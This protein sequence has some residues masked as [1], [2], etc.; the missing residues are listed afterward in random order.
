M[1]VL[2]EEDGINRGL[3][4]FEVLKNILEWSDV[5]FRKY[6]SNV[7]IQKERISAD[8]AEVVEVLCLQSTKYLPGEAK[9]KETISVI[10]LMLLNP[11]IE[12]LG[13]V[14]GKVIEAKKPGEAHFMVRKI[15]AIRALGMLETESAVNIL[16]A[17]SSYTHFYNDLE[18]F[19]LLFRAYID[20]MVSLALLHDRLFS[21][22]ISQFLRE[23]YSGLKKDEL[24]REVAA[25]LGRIYAGSNHPEAAKMLLQMLNEERKIIVKAELI[26]AL[27]KLSYSD[28]ALKIEVFRKVFSEMNFSVE[29]ALAGAIFMLRQEYRIDIAQRVILA[30][31]NNRSP[32]YPF[33]YLYRRPSEPSVT[34][35]LLE[36]Q[37]LSG[38][39]PRIFK[40][41]DL[42]QG[43]LE[44][45]SQTSEEVSDKIKIEVLMT[46]ARYGEW[47][48]VLSFP[49]EK[50]FPENKR[51]IIEVAFSSDNI[52]PSTFRKMIEKLFSLYDDDLQ[53]NVFELLRHNG[54]AVDQKLKILR[55]DLSETL[56][57]CGSLNDLNNRGYKNPFMKKALDE[58]LTAIQ[59]TE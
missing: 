38:L 55:G 23:M 12:S 59:E 5:A 24:R 32:R 9:F 39:Q 28:E 36:F 18:A 49:F 48:S 37:R 58:L 14:L 8:I 45:L 33:F 10:A 21:P 42:R 3:I 25:A 57:L 19:P 6:L 22:K 20:E 27:S 29:Q 2:I 43:L 56:R 16:I 53:V 41:V 7:I 44:L 17:S 15:A 35:L 1:I 11:R 51:R 46:Y 40:M 31:L 50:L 47:K 4:G 30:I 52:D 34:T 54:V 13:S 26:F